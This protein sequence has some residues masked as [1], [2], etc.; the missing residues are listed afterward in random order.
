MTAQHTPKQIAE[1]PAREVTLLEDR[2]RVVRRGQ[3]QLP[4]GLVRLRVENVAPVLS[5]KTLT[6]AIAQ[7]GAR[8]ADV[9]VVR[10]F[11]VDDQDSE[12]TTES[13]LTELETQ[14]RELDARIESMETERVVLE[15][16]ASGLDKLAIT[17]MTELSEDVSW[18]QSVADGWREQMAELNR[19]ERDLRDRLVV[20]AT[21]L[22]EL[23]R[24]RNRLDQR[25]ART[26]SPREREFAA[27]EADIDVAAAGV[28]DIALEYVVP[29][30]CWRP[31]HT[32]RLI[33]GSGDSA[34]GAGDQVVF[35]T[36]ACIWQ[37]TG[38]DWSD[39]QLVLS[40]E[41]ASLG[42]EPPPLSSDILR[43][44]RKSDA[45]VVE[46]REQEVQRLGPGAEDS[47]SV[48]SPDV[49]GIDDGGEA[50]NLRTARPSTIPSDGRP[51]RVPLSS[52][53]CP[54][55]VTVIAMPELMTC[56]LTRSEQ[57]N[58]GPGP[59]LAG[60]VDLIRDSGLVGRTSVLF[61]AQN[62]RFELGWGPE[63]DLRI[64]R[65]SASTEEKS[66]LL[67]SWVTRIRELEIRLSNLGQH[68]R[69]LQVTERIPVSEIDKVKIAVDT[70]ATTQGK[71]ADDNGF[72]TWQVALAAGAHERIELK[73]KL[74][75]HED[76]YGI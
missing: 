34:E 54:A 11:I 16:H 35:S 60:P 24:T 10:E 68:P 6:G 13:Q 57:A 73:Y 23:R 33:V 22:D 45:V 59:I 8:I 18:G 63:P 44:R 31:Y 51:H 62:E 74:E 65:N 69:T 2:A 48:V 50:L 5:D 30:A 46:A 41:R 55:T 12:G 15:R 28:F 27:I 42:T 9:R 32:A 43:V 52:F 21:E 71:R 38:E 36:D 56:A 17:T 7:D 70:E 61:V 3:L 49:P 66:R 76:V 1:V 26:Q 47:Q 25:I 40:T 29:S 4:A 19:S 67:S 64:K 53:Q 58:Q 14:A 75:R 39:V 72:V 37:N 20:L